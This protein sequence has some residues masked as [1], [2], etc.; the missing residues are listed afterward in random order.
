VRDNAHAFDPM[1][2][3]SDM[4]DLHV[5]FDDLTGSE[6]TERSLRDAVTKYERVA[7]TGCSG[8][9]KTSVARF[10]LDP[11]PDRIAPI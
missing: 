10:S 4:R 8:A 5:P 9:G 3:D 1:L 6:T 11:A 2:L 7:L